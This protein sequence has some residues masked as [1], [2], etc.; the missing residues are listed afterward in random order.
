MPAKKYLSFLS[1]R[2]REVSG[3]VVSS[4]AANDG[5]FPALDAAGKLDVSVMPSGIGV[6]TVS[7]TATEALAANDLVN[8]H[9]GGVRKADATTEGKEAHGFVKASVAS[10]ASATIYLPGDVITGLA[11][12]TQGARYFLHTTAGLTTATAPAAT[13]NVA[14]LV[15]I[16]NSTTSIMF[17]P[18]EPITRA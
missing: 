12:L 16:A 11:G 8:I 6:N 3:V 7:A 9:A 14:Q 15:G 10:A 18:E 1:G 5:D 13:G 2:N 4:G 17:E